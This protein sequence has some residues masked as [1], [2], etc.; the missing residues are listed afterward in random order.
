MEDDPCP[1][2]FFVRG[3]QVSTRGGGVDG[4]AGANLSR[5]KVVVWVEARIHM[6][7]PYGA[8]EC[9][10]KGGRKTA[11]TEREAHQA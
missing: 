6:Q 9:I 3:G 5:D 1:S 8:C 4:R 10:D 2:H 7:S 11:H